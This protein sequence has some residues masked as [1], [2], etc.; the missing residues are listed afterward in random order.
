MIPKKLL[1]TYSMGRK[2]RQLFFSPLNTIVMTFPWC[3]LS[4]EYYIFKILLII[5][6]NIHLSKNTFFKILIFT[7][8]ILNYYFITSYCHEIG[9]S[10]KNVNSF[11]RSKKIL[12]RKSSVHMCVFRHFP[13]IGLVRILRFRFETAKLVLRFSNS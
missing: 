13:V 6:I 7:S 2:V 12:A 9:Q 8:S 5:N 3:S 4:T 1:K 11:L 10:V